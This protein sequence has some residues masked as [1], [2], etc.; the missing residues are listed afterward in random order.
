MR[1]ECLISRYGMIILSR[2]FVAGSDGVFVSS[3]SPT[4]KLRNTE[5]AVPH[6]QVQQSNFSTPATRMEPATVP[7]KQAWLLDAYSACLT[8]RTMDRF[9]I[10]YW[11]TF[12]R[13]RCHFPN[14]LPEYEV[15]CQS[16]V[17]YPPDY[18]EMHLMGVAQF[19]HTC[20]ED[21]VCVDFTLPSVQG[22][23]IY[24]DIECVRPEDVKIIEWLGSASDAA[25]SKYSVGCSESQVIPGSDYSAVSGSQQVHFI[26]T[27]QVTYKNRMSYTAPLLFIRDRTTPGHIFDRVY[28]PDTGI[29]SATM[30]LSSYRGRIQPRI[31]Q[32]CMAVRIHDPWVVMAFT[33]FQVTG[34]KAKLLSGLDTTSDL[35]IH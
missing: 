8:H 1:L 18:N 22:L 11:F 12:K 15:S 21:T 9:R 19:N 5:S 33:W 4:E 35:L 34:R 20:P 16:H 23:G 32:F 3:S 17:W 31:I 29:A 24:E 28:H 25:N 6:G 27:E 13:A 30:T 10:R 14:E 7:D 26:V 2:I